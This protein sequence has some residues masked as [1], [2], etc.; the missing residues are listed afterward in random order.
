MNKDEIKTCEAHID[1]ITAIIANMSAMIDAEKN[2]DAVEI[3][4]I[5]I[6]QLLKQI[7]GAL[8]VQF[9]KKQIDLTLHN[10]GKVVVKSDKNKLSQSIYNILTNA[11]KFTKPMGTVSV[12][13]EMADDVVKITIEDTGTGIGREQIEHLF[14]AYYRGSNAVDIPGEGIGLYV[15]KENL[16]K[17]H[18]QI[19]VESEIGRGSRFIITVPSKYRIYPKRHDSKQKANPYTG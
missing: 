13:Y 18:G 9:G 14:N 4:D 7:V 15:V 17:I 11:Y 2:L 3:E 12:S 10:H 8:K 1:S 19:H 6:N 5:E 16:N